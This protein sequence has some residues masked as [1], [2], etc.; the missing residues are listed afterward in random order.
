MT[1][2][3]DRIYS[4]IA[5]KAVKRMTRDER[6]IRVL[7]GTKLE[8][9]PERLL[10]VAT[11]FVMTKATSKLK[12]VK[13]SG[14]VTK[15][16]YKDIEVGV[17]DTGIGTPSA[18][19]IVEGLVRT[20]PQLLI[21][22]DF[23]GGLLNDQAIGNA[24]VADDAIVGDGCSAVYFGSEVKVES[25]KELTNLVI[26]SAKEVGLT[27]HR[28][29]MWTTDVLLKQTKPLLEQWIQKG[30]SAVDMETTAILGIS[31]DESIPAASLNCISDLPAKGQ[32]PFDIEGVSPEL[33]TGLNLTIEAG[34]NALISWES[35]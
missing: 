20:Q 33:L 29:S 16:T 22:T 9:V 35:D 2:M 26:T 23:C 7:L 14:N 18:A 25:H 15:G 19:M 3:K 4:A 1:R 13:V 10:L 27:V 31:A 17:V 28:G 30:A 5:S 34:L 11:T 32:G 24:F 6:I 21:R 8:N 12:R